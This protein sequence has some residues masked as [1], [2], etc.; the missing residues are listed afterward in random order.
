MAMRRFV[1]CM[2]LIGMLGGCTSIPIMLWKNPVLS[3]RLDF[4]GSTNIRAYGDK[5]AEEAMKLSELE[6]NK[7]DILEKLKEQRDVK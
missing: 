6:Q 3:L 7:L 4:F 1:A 2:L 5:A